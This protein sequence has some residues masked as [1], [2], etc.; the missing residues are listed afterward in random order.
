MK[1][2]KNILFRMKLKGRG[3]VN[4]DSNKQKEVFKNLETQK[5][6]H[7]R[8]TTDNVMYAKKKFYGTGDDTK[9]KIVISP[10]ALRH[11][12]FA[13][14]TEIQSATLIHH[15]ELLYAYMATPTS[16]LRGYLFAKDETFKRTS[17]LRLYEVEQ[18]NDAISTLE[19]FSK[20][21]YKNSDKE[22][23]GSDPTLYEKETIGDVE[24]TG[25]GCID[26]MQ[27]QF[28]SCDQVHG[29]YA[30]NPDMFPIYKG[31]MQ[32]KMPSFNSELKYYTQIGSDS[33]EPEYGYLLSNE[34]IL[35]I[36]RD[37]IRKIAN[38]NI[39]K[40]NAYAKTFELEYKLVYD[41]IDDN[42]FTDENDNWIKITSEDD[43][44]A[45]DFETD[46]FYEEKD[47]EE[48]KKIREKIVEKYEAIK[49]KKKTERLE[50]AESIKNKKA[51]N[52]E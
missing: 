9:Y 49:L 30:F 45:I 33:K 6:S 10:Q 42:M 14:E 15:D 2:V 16:I 25:S 32:S 31:L 20:S 50:R 17:A 48:A 19:F 7:L 1:K 8:R 3:I 39:K 36:V 34:N 5:F 18:T 40:T 24:Y 22:K 38:L 23:E 47:E 11:Y 13:K 41:A 28:V 46:F 35:E 12:I 43:I 44:N 52:N 51:R 37:T 26:L 21:G 27:L 29:R 4:Y